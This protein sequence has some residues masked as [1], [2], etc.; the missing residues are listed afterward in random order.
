[1]AQKSNMEEDVSKAGRFDGGAR[2]EHENHAICGCS[3]VAHLMPIDHWMSMI[4]VLTAATSLFLPP[5][6]P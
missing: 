3:Y 2:M 4:K 1:M 5:R 6:F